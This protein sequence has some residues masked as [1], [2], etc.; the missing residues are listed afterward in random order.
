[1][2]PHLHH[3][4]NMCP[5][6]VR[7]F[8]VRRQRRLLRRQN[9]HVHSS[10]ST[11]SSSSTD[12]VHEKVLA[13]LHIEHSRGSG[14]SKYMAQLLSEIIGYG[15]TYELFRLRFV[16]VDKSGCCEEQSQNSSPL[17][18]AQADILFTPDYWRVRHATLLDMQRQLDYP[19]LFL[20]IAPY[21]WTLSQV[22]AR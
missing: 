22:G 8:D 11:A 10:S 7:H 16:V 17:G 21:D 14:K 13:Q 12:H 18:V 9:I 4:T 5:T 20:R 1:M 6:Y 19:T 15:C 2:C 3:T